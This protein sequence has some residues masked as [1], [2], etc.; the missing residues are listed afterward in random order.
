[1]ID[2]GTRHALFQK[3]D[4]VLGEEEATTLMQ[5]LPPVGWADVAT[6]E[7]VDF[8]LQAT[9]QRLREFIAYEIKGL[10]SEL[11]GE[12]GSLRS[13]FGSLRSE[14]GGEI[15]SLRSEIS[16]VRDEITRQTRA[17][18]YSAVGLVVTF[19]LGFASVVVAVAQMAR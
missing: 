2:E 18:M 1:M 15:G 3:L 19:V 10:R 5:H 12:I 11:M 9:E 7:Y 8:R 14:I 4:H 17:M 6:R 13:E 16:G